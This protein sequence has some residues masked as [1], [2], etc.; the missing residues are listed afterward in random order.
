MSW[1]FFEPFCGVFC[2]PHFPPLRTQKEPSLVRPHR[3]KLGGGR[4]LLVPVAHSDN[5]DKLSLLYPLE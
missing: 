2:G 5:I 4:T 3:D 1:C